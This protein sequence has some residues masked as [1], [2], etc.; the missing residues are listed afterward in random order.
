MSSLYLG[1]LCIIFDELYFFYFVINSQLICSTSPKL[2]SKPSLS[3]ILTFLPAVLCFCKSITLFQRCFNTITFPLW[4][5]F[6][7]KAFQSSFS[8][9]RGSTWIFQGKMNWAIGTKEVLEEEREKG[10]SYW[11]H[12][13]GMQKEFNRV[14]LKDL[15]DKV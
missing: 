3:L 7:W 15:A 12:G 4:I 9:W 6:P 8:S 10:E 13:S 2:E 14:Q 1:N 11:G 5:L